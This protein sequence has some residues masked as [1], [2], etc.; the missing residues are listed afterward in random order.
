V[1][2]LYRNSSIMKSNAFRRQILAEN[3]HDEDK[4][5]YNEPKATGDIDQK[6]EVSHV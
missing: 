3:M 6:E 1:D 5:A 2:I 4:A